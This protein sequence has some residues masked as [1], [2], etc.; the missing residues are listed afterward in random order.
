MSLV[1]V[2]AGAFPEEINLQIMPGMTIRFSVPPLP[3]HIRV[4]MW[5]LLR[6][7]LTTKSYCGIRS[8][9]L[10]LEKL[11]AKEMPYWICHLDPAWNYLLPRNFRRTKNPFIKQ[12]SILS[13]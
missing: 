9:A 2:Q 8:M 13:P 7:G 11:K 6:A 1:K 12:V 3:H 4:A 5:S 10:P